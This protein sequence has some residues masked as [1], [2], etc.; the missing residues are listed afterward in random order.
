MRFMNSKGTVFYGMHFYPGVA[1]YAE[2]GKDPY[3]VFLNEDTIRSMGP[4]FAGRPVFVMHVD[5]VDDKVDDLRKDA[6]GWVIES[7]Y[8]Q[9]DGKHWVKFLV[10]S[11]KGERA[12]RNGMK[13]SNCYAPKGPFG[14]GGLWNGVQ[15]AKEIKGGEY[16]HLA[17]VPNPRYEESVILTP[18]QFK[19]HNEDKI[20]ELKRLANDKESKP[21]KLNLFKRT[22]VEN[23]TDMDG[24]EVLLEKSG[25]VLTITQL[26]KEADERY[27]NSP[28][29]AHP[30]HLVDMGEGSKMTVNDL[31]AKHK[32]MCSELED[33][34]K[35]GAEK[36]DDDVENDD[37]SFDK[38]DD[39][40]PIA[41]TNQ[42]KED[43]DDKDDKKENED[44]KDKDDKKENEEDKAEKKK[45]ELEEARLQKEKDKKAKEKA[46]KLRNAHLNATEEVA[47]VELSEDRVARGKARY[48]S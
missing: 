16:E 40:T 38:A 46:D 43:K 21:M 5:G 14:Q 4:S 44:D 3:R 45:N 42:N 34:K 10:V 13:L 11:E 28:M 41:G 8:N 6:D 18:E 1:E 33:L 2:P 15:Y 32:S 23:S 37:D 48:G 24:V 20:G 39:S 25:K 30:E 29:A 36:T 17:I 35:K 47:R 19:K 9:A 27:S 26:V 22:K 12:I 31:V 7:F